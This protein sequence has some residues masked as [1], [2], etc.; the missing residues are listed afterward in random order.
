MPAFKGYYKKYLMYSVDFFFSF[1]CATQH[2]G[3]L[4]PQP[5]IYLVPPEVE[6][7]SIN[8]QTSRAVHDAISIKWVARTPV[9]W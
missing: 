6:A 8:H 3:I 4:V 2:A 7:W 9:K 1:G 5:R